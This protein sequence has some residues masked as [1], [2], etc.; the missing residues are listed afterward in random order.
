[1]LPDDQKSSEPTEPIE[2]MFPD[3]RYDRV[4]RTPSSEAYLLS[5]GES[6]FGRV[7]LH[8]GTSVVHDTLLCLTDPK[9]TRGKLDPDAGGKRW[10]SLIT[11]ANVS[12]LLQAEGRKIGAAVPAD[13]ADAQN[14][15]T[16]HRTNKGR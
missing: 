15:Y 12:R 4:C 10:D 16:L 13:P 8:F 9:Y 14:V 2:L 7:D 5:E 6:P 1:M 11:F 3:L